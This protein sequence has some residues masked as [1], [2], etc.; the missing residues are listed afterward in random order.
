MLQ[1][2]SSSPFPRSH[3]A[4]SAQSRVPSADGLG[5]AWAFFSLSYSLDDVRTQLYAD[6]VSNYV[7]M[8]RK[9]GDVHSSLYT[10]SPAMH[11]HVLG[12]ILAAD[13]RP[14]T[15]SA[16]VGR[17]QNLRVAVQRRWNNA[18]SDT[19][20]QQSIEV[21]LGLH[22]ERNF[23]GV[24]VRTNGGLPFSDLSGPDPDDVEQADQGPEAVHTCEELSSL[25]M[26][27]HD[28]RFG[29]QGSASNLESPPPEDCGSGKV[30]E[31]EL[32]NSGKEQVVGGYTTTV[33]IALDPLGAVL[34]STPMKGTVS[35]R[36]DYED[37]EP[38][39]DSQAADL[40]L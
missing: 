15:A 14:Y 36:W 4:L 10:G 6:A 31:E 26:T 27:H 8:F 18:V 9:H 20:R 30:D 24:H 5:P 11:S 21:F 3:S 28:G 34:D 25:K 12:Q 19:S 37:T 22:L 39:L 23:P 32:S 1:Q 2:R 33:G 13:A 35:G 29:V 7:S 40:L 38:S 17:L 16:S